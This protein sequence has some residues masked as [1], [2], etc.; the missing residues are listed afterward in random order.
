[1]RLIIRSQFEIMVRIVITQRIFWAH[2]ITEGFRGNGRVCKVGK[3][4]I[5][6]M[7]NLTVT[8]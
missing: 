2:Y 7:S 1:M 6:G 5:Y 8:D 3:L 4:R